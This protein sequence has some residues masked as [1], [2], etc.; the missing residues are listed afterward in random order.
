MSGKMG[1]KETGRKPATAKRQ[2]AKTDGAFGHE[3][4]DRIVPGDANR[5]E[6]K[7]ERRKHA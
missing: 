4:L 3:G 5:N 7:V 1:K 6:D 2:S